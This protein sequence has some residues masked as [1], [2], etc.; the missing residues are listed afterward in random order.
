MCRQTGSR[1]DMTGSYYASICKY[2]NIQKRMKKALLTASAYT[3]LF[4]VLESLV[5]FWKKH[6]SSIRSAET[7]A[8]FAI[9]ISCS[10]D[11][12]GVIET[13]KIS[14]ILSTE[15]AALVFFMQPTVGSHLTSKCC[16][17]YIYSS[18][19]RLGVASS[20][21]RR[22]LEKRADGPQVPNV[23]GS[24]VLIYWSITMNFWVIGIPSTSFKTENS[25]KL[26]KSREA[27]LDIA[28]FRVLSHQEV[29]SLWFLRK[30]RLYYI[31][32]IKFKKVTK[33]W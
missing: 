26:I 14:S 20:L 23:L 24:S 11:L 10:V 29:H 5:W 33:A 19:L 31:S 1:T 12:L 27:K 4:Q 17:F 21:F 15:N 2:A 3:P 13:I 6:A 25:I 32:N 16:C 7:V 9:V 8:T 18:H 28:L 30:V 22:T